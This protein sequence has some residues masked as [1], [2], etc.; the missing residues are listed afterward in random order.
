MNY[1]LLFK[2]LKAEIGSG[3]QF[4][5]MTSP[6]KAFATIATI[7]FWISYIAM[8]IIKYVY[9]FVFNCLASTVEYL[10]KWVNETKKGVNTW[11]TEAIIYVITLPIIFTFRCFLALFSASFYI[12]WFFEMCY[13]FIASLGGARWQPFISEATFDETKKVKATTNVVAANTI[14]L[15]GFIL[16][17]LVLL[18]SI[19][20]SESS[21]LSSISAILS[22]L[23][24]LF[25]IIA[26]PCTF[27]TTLVSID[28]DDS[29][30]V[31]TSTITTAVQS[32]FKST[33]FEEEFPDI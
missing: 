27:K 33:D 31:A 20:S 28:E 22:V 19:L 1:T 16:L 15:I 9:L 12:C 11:T 7:P 26:V 21:A 2:N 10:E 8:L 6:F 23:Y 29:E 13:G 18:L 3:I 24:F 30:T 4:K 17:A 14:S 32:G 5:R 25:M